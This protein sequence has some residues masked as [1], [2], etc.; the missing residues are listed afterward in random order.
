MPLLKN[1]TLFATLV[2]AASAQLLQVD[3][4]REESPVTFTTKRPRDDNDDND[5]FTCKKNRKNPIRLS[6]CK[7]G[8]GDNVPFNTKKNGHLSNCVK[9]RKDNAASTAASVKAKNKA[10]ALL[11]KQTTCEKHPWCNWW[12]TA[13]RRCGG[14][15]AAQSIVGSATMKDAKKS[16]VCTMTRD[17]VGSC[18]GKNCA[19]CDYGP[20][21][22]M[23]EPNH[24]R[25]LS[26]DRLDNSRPHTSD[27]SQMQAVCN[28]CNAFKWIYSI[29]RVL[30]IS[31]GVVAVADANNV[32]VHSDVIASLEDMSRMKEKLRHKEDR[33]KRSGKKLK[34]EEDWVPFTLTFDEAIA[35]LRAQ[36]HCC[37]LCHL[38]LSVDDYS[39]DQTV[40]KKGYTADNVTF[41]HHGC[42]A[43]K[44][45]WGIESAVETARRI[46]AF[47]SSKN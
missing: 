19:L 47:W 45:D 16:L 2:V 42:N 13:G 43:L 29:E 40:A 15:T 8:H 46:V 30:E 6:N 25:Q 38:A 5:Q 31:R 26:L 32:A 37:S 21:Y 39:F 41:M 4:I 18:M 35:Q 24:P 10:R 14:C 23:Q 3:D 17:F 22:P 33:R 34:K 44:G 11:P 36:Q 1:I 28:Q 27:F 7:N 20:L 9:C 12:D